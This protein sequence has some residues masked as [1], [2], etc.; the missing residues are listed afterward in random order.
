MK[1]VLEREFQVP[2]TWVEETSRNTLEN[3]RGSFQ[4][5]GAAGIRRVYLVT[6][7]WHMPRARLR[8][9]IVRAST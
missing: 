8:V 1:Q 4:V 6:H 2:V 5:L 3:A 7:A 9:R